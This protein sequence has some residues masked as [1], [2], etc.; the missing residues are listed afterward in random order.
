MGDFKRLAAI[1]TMA[2][3][4]AV[5]L[6][7]CEKPESTHSDIQNLSYGASAEANSSNSSSEESS[8]AEPSPEGDSETAPKD[9]DCGI[10]FSESGAAIT[11]DGAVAEGT[12]VK[13]SK[14]GVYSVKGSCSDGSITVDA[15]KDDKVTIMLEGLQL[16]CSNGSAVDCEEAKKLV[17]FLADGSENTLS[18]AAY[19]SEDADAPDSAVFSRSDMVISGSGT[20]NVN[21]L[22]NDGIKSKDG[23]TVEGGNIDVTSV[24][25]GIVGRDYIRITGGAVTVNAAGD[26]LKSTNDKD[27]AKG[28]ITISEGCALD[29][30]S[31]KDGIQS[32]T[33]LS[34]DGGK[35]KIFAGGEAANAEVKASESPFDRDRIENTE[36]VKGLKA[37]ADIRITGGEFDII[38][39][40][41]CIHSNANVY[42]DNGT[43]TL[44]S[45]DDGIHADESLKISDGAFR[46]TKSYEGLEGK[47][48]DVSGGTIDIK[49]ADDGINA[50]GGDNGQFFGYSEDSDEY[51]ISISGGEIT[52]DSEG[53]GIDSN[54]TV[55]MSGGTVTVYGPT[56][57]GNGA[58]DYEKSFAVSGGTLMAFGSRGMAQAPS[59]LSQPCL[60]IYAT[61]QSGSKVEV[62]GENGSV[63]MSAALPKSAESLIFTSDKLKQGVEYG[64]YA[65]GKLLQTVTADEGISGGGA[66]GEGFGGGMGGSGGF[67]G[68]GHGFGR[69]DGSFT[70]PDGAGRPGDFD[71]PERPAA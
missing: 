38:S 50:A 67:G 32:E 10:E 29:I 42:I 36:S 59:T 64:I 35:I 6:S 31:G 54:G 51:Y 18:D 49:A 14:A 61:V 12:A 19:V 47:N 16:S 71:V 8:E 65:D 30:V 28:Y 69:G 20:L 27:S 45:C 58:L 34:V 43:F 13:I 15:G 68:M 39:L 4:F 40:D 9:A 46:I 23:L 57:S 48:I 24:D 70:P 22:F 62:R 53:D 60:S 55:A 2:Q 3:L 44:S 41:D 66:N 7:A 11:G 25:D 1:L 52:V 37:G 21:G 5:T 56:S 33:S 63:I 26:G 17:L